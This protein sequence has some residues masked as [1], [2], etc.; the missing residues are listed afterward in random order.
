MFFPVF[1]FGFD[2]F[3]KNIDIECSGLRYT[4]NKNYQAPSYGQISYLI[5]S[6]CAHEVI[7]YVCAD[8]RFLHNKRLF[9]NS[10][11]YKVSVY[12]NINDEILLEQRSV[13]P[14]QDRLHDFDIVNYVTLREV[15]GLNKILLNDTVNSFLIAGCSRASR[16]IGY[17]IRTYSRVLERCLDMVVDI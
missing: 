14:S 11:N 13:S 1:D 2:V 12:D 3:T 7:K 5:S 9:I 8:T 15:D 16:D 6:I 10:D 4:I 17:E